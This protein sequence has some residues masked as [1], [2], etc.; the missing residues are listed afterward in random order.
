[1]GAARECENP[2]RRLY[3]PG[4]SPAPAGAACLGRA[5]AGRDSGGD[6]HAGRRDAAGG[7]PPRQGGVALCELP[8]GLREHAEHAD[9]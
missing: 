8:G 4:A 6:G 2:E 7:D 5:D 9:V 3:Q 1:M